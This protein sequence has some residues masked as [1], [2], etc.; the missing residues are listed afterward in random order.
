LSDAGPTTL[1]YHAR[2]GRKI[3]A[4]FKLT[5]LIHIIIQ[6]EA[7]R[8]RT[9]LTQCY[10]CQQ[11]RQIGQIARNAQASCG[12]EVDTAIKNDQKKT[13]TPHLGAATAS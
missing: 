13:K 7:Y 12:A 6:V 8:A 2:T 11:F 3:T 4:D 5:Q 1:P 9:G 10:N